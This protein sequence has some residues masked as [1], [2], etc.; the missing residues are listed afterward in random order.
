[1]KRGPQKPSIATVKKDMGKEVGQF[2]D[3]AQQ[4]VWQYK[5]SSFQ[6]GGTKI[7]RFLPKKLLNFRNWC[8]EEHGASEANTYNCS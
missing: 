3:D 4:A 5:L 7:E 8:M 2:Q 6:V 1:M